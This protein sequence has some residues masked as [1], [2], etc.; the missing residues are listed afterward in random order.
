MNRISIDFCQIK[1]CLYVGKQENRLAGVE[2]TILTSY[3][4]GFLR[5]L[6]PNP[7]VDR[8]GFA[9]SINKQIFFRPKEK[10]KDKKKG[11][12]DEPTPHQSVV[13]PSIIKEFLQRFPEYGTRL[14]LLMVQ[15]S[16]KDTINWKKRVT[17]SSLNKF[18][19]NTCFFPIKEHC[20]W[21]IEQ[22]SQ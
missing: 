6:Q 16:L 1:L 5:F 14:M 17:I 3:E 8:L 13:H 9:R 22:F 10:S 19:F 15:T 2:E 20:L 11:K 4:A 21:D 7:Y 18:F 12:D